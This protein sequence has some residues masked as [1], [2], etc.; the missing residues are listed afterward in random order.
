MRVKFEFTE[1]E[2]LDVYRRSLKRSPTIGSSRRK[3]RVWFSI[4]A[5][6]L[7]FLLLS[8]AKGQM[9]GLIVGALSGLIAA[10]LHPLI[11]RRA[12]EKRLRKLVREHHDCT[13]PRFCEVELTPEGVWSRQAKT[14]VIHEWGSIE[15]IDLTEHG[16]EI[17]GKGCG[18]MVRNRAFQSDADRQQFLELANSYHQSAGVEG[19]T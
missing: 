15:S 2:L 5:G 4:L 19:K 1:D 18:L 12:T 14:Q 3:D 17:I 6:G 13:E 8:M 16:V 11:Y 9:V 10:L 7:G